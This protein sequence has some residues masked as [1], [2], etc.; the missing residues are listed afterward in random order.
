MARRTK[1]DGSV[2]Q[3]ADG[4]WCGSIENGHDGAGNRR[5]KV[6]T[7]K[8]QAEVLAKLRTIRRQREEF[9]HVPT[10]VPTVGAWLDQWLDEVCAPRLKPKTVDGYRHKVGLIKRSIGR[11]KL[12]RL[13]TAD[14]RR[15]HREVEDTTSATTAMHCHRVLHTAVAKAVRDGVVLRNV[16]GFE[17]TPKASHVE[18]AT[19]N[20]TQAKAL[21]RSRDGD[22]LA[23][24]WLIALLYGVRQGEALGLTWDCVDYERGVIDLAW[25]LQRINWSH[26]CSPACGSTRAVACPRR[27]HVLPRGME[28]RHLEGAWFLTRP[29]RNSARVVPLLPVAEAALRQRYDLTATWPNPHGLVFARPDGKPIDPARDNEAWHKALRGAGLPD[30]PLHNARHSAATMLQSLGA[31]EG[32]RMAI[33]GHS[34]AATARHY[35]HNDLGDATV[36]LAALEAALS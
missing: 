24:R 26:G 3:R 28:A 8:T 2:Y 6:V 13:S 29:K 14:I 11:V 21:L 12:D 5:R 31:S 15:M 35:A 16:V 19:L 17:D 7:A 33:L 23:A 10:G 30:M 1:G 34:V 18:A 27:R 22:P 20:A 4:R 32:V 9:G 36:A 25:Q